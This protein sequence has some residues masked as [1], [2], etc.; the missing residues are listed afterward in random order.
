MR[1]C[2]PFLLLVCVA[3]PSLAQQRLTLPRVSPHARVMQTIGMTDLTV[4]YHR[5]AVDG[6]LIWNELVPYGKV[7]RAG[8]NENTTFETSTEIQVEGVTLPA[9][10]YGLHMIPGVNEWTILFSSMADAWGSFSYDASEDVARVTV[11]PREATPQE[12]LSYRFDDPDLNSTTLV[13]HWEHLEVPIRITADTPSLVLLSMETE[14]RGTPGVFP[15]GWDQIATFA[16]DSGL[17]TEDALAW[18]ERSIANRP[19]FSNQMTKARAL[20]A[21]GRNDE[22]MAL[23]RVTL[24]EARE[25]DVET[26]VQ[27]RRRTGHGSEADRVEALFQQRETEE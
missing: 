13:L 11:I 15:E 14:L 1:R 22:A 26:Y 17:R 24:A 2:V 3:A 7:W 10:R 6:R 12:R 27:A 9:G 16:L 21:L 8:A 18:A 25:S 5:P 20:D 4:D 19:M 23:R